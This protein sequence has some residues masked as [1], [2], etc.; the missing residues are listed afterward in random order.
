MGTGAITSYIDVAQLVLYAFWIFFFGLIYWLQRESKR[1]GYPM[2]SDRP[3][4]A[5]VD[6]LLDMPPTKT[7][8][9][10]DGS[11][12]EA[13]HD[14]DMLPQALAAEPVAAFPG[15]PLDPIGNPMHAGVGPGAWTR[16]LDFP[17]RLSDGSTVI[18]PLRRA[19]GMT[20]SPK[21]IDPRG[22]PVLGADGE[23]GGIVREIWLDR[24]EFIVRYLELDIANGAKGPQVLLPMGFAKIGRDAVTV[25]ALM[26]HQFADVPRLR[27]PDEV[28]S[29]DEDRITAYYGAGT[30]YAEPGRAESLL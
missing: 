30:L 2:H 25:R 16:R 28:T 22:L 13:P 6:G 19:P 11:T 3:G 18:V 9:M 5:Y 8:L 1:E 15:A 23:V 7:Y 24:A 27:H 29:L 26:G 20:V 14:R 12:R 10:A 21:D 4:R 17:E